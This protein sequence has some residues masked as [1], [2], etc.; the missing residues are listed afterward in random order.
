L[1][2]SRILGRWPE[3]LLPHRWQDLGY[4]SLKSDCYSA[5]LCQRTRKLRRLAEK[6]AKLERSRFLPFDRERTA[7]DYGRLPEQTLDEVVAAGEITE[8]ERE[9][10]FFV[11]FPAADEVERSGNGPPIPRRKIP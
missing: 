2:K 5:V 9:K 4:S 7:A 1:L 3:L 6:I 11:R 10:V 8:Q